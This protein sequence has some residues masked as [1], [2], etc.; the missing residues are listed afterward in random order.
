MIHPRPAARAACA[1]TVALCI[2]ANSSGPARAIPPAPRARCEDG[3]AS[4]AA[5]AVPSAMS[6]YAVRL[7]PG[8]DLRQELLAFTRAHRLRAGAVLTCAGSLARVALRHANQPAASAREGHFEILSLTGTLD[9]LGGHLHLCVADSTGAA[10]G[11]HL[12]DGCRI[13]TTA[14][15]VI[16]E[17]NDVEFGREVDSTYGYRELVVRARRAR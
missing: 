15:I 14:E 1:A 12:W 16:G 13:Y 7:A 4:R 17:M 2:V 5:R 8:Q 11:G 6:T 9:S 10:S 3:P